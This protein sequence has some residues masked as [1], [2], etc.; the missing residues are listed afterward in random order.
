MRHRTCCTEALLSF[1][2][3]SEIADLTLTLLKCQAV[4]KYMCAHNE[5]NK[6]MVG[7][8]PHVVKKM[9][10]LLNSSFLQISV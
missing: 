8:G 4:V 1:S 6:M 5:G 7:D 3:G 10:K 9:L 2:F